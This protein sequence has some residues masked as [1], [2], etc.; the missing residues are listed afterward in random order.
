MH[1]FHFWLKTNLTEKCYFSLETLSSLQS[2]PQS[3]AGSNTLDCI[4]S[5]SKRRKKKNAIADSCI[6]S[7]YIAFTRTLISSTKR[8][9]LKSKQ[10]RIAYSLQP[11]DFPFF[12]FQTAEQI[13][14]SE[15]GTHRKWWE[16]KKGGR[17]IDKK[18]STYIK[19][20]ANSAG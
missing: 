17:Q 4:Y 7:L 14:K 3:H 8:P 9:Y 6:S 13:K 2:Q 10:A 15:Y 11:A 18:I 5:F 12:V 20:A 19:R 1:P 16:T